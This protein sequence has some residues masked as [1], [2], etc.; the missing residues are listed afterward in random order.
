[1]DITVTMLQQAAGLTQVKRDPL[2]FLDE[3][4][5]GAAPVS[6][7][8][9]E[10]LLVGT[11]A[12]QRLLSQDVLRPLLSA[13]IGVEVMDTQAAARTYNILMAEAD[14]WSSPCCRP[15]EIPPYDHAHRQTRPA[16][17]RRKHHR[18]AQP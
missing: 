15:T 9:P 16:F 1:A 17:H 5:A 18:P 2:A 14:A 8:G 10:V 11:G 12:R 3:P 13:G 6:A 7:N 4:E